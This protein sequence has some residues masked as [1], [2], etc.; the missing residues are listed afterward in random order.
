M[1]NGCYTK[2]LYDLVL[3]KI[4]DP[5][6]CMCF[7]RQAA[8]I[9]GLKLEEY[10]KIEWNF[11]ALNSITAIDSFD[12]LENRVRDNSLPAIFS[13]LVQQLKITG[14]DLKFKTILSMSNAIKMNKSLNELYISSSKIDPISAKIISDAIQDHVSLQILTVTETNMGTEG[15]TSILQSIKNSNVKQLNLVYNKIGSKTIFTF[16]SGLLELDISNNNLGSDGVKK[17]AEYL[18]KNQTLKKLSVSADLGIGLDGNIALGEAIKL[19]NTLESLDLSY[20]NASVENIN[21]FLELVASNSTFKEV[22]FS[23]NLSD[24]NSKNRVIK[25]AGIQVIL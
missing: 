2:Q 23:N 4:E 19:N 20:T 7:M 8:I 9:I 22:N 12:Q 17:I 16:P 21:A 25:P 15:A 10:K 5:V 24:F 11:D 1:D 18:T 14:N 6:F 13:T 3:D